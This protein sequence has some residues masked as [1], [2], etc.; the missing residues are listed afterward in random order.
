MLVDVETL[1]LLA[2]GDPQLA[3]GLQRAEQ[4]GG[5]DRDPR[6]DPGDADDFPRDVVELLEYFRPAQPNQALR[7]VP[8][9]GQDVE[10]WILGSSTFGAQLAAYLGLPYAFASHFAPTQMMDAI[11]V[12]RQRF[13]PSE[14]LAAPHVMIGVNV[15]AAETEAEARL[16]F[17]SLQQAFVNLRSGRPT[18]LQPPVRG[19]LELL[20]PQER[21]MLDSVLSCSAIGSPASVAE[22]LKAFI[23][24][25]RADELMITSQIFDHAARLRSYEITAEIHKAG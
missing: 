18:R 21:A 16:L 5:G 2:L 10:A 20:A 7:A 4:D 1:D 22:Q 15:F 9:E 6:H 13:R 17:S 23:A 11:A 25:T 8:G 14:R 24:H 19:Y 12:Y 3:H